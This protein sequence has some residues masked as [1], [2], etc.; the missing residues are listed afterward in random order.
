MAERLPTAEQQWNSYPF[1]IEM[2]RHELNS[3][4]EKVGNCV[5]NP[6][7]D[8]SMVQSDP[9]ESSSSSMVS[10][11]SAISNAETVVPGYERNMMIRKLIGKLGNDY[12]S[13]SYTSSQPLIKSNNANTQ[14]SII[15]KLNLPFS[16]DPGFAE[17]ADRF[18]SFNGELGFNGNEF[19]ANIPDFKQES[20][21]VSEKIPGQN[22]VNS[23]VE[24]QRKPHQWQLLIAR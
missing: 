15:P 1:G 6:N 9:F 24:K 12:N 16:S 13:S 2:Q 4:S 5:F 11:S 21:L 20:L 18:S 10:S 7:W 17:R 22:N 23:R 8:N 3:A 19:Q 14:L